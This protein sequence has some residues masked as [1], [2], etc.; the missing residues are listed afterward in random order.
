MAVKRRYLPLAIE[1][2]WAILWKKPRKRLRDKPLFSAFIGVTLSVIPLVLVIQVSDAM[3]SGILNRHLETLSGH[4]QVQF[5]QLEEQSHLQ[6]YIEEL[7]SIKGVKNLHIEHSG[8]GL[9]LNKG[10]RNALQVRGLPPDIFSTD[11][12]F[13]E[14][15]KLISGSFS[16]GPHEIVLADDLARQLQ[17]EVGD[18]ISLLTAAKFGKS[19]QLR[20]KLRSYTLT[21]IISTG[22]QE[23]DRLWAF[24][25]LEEA[26]SFFHSS[27]SQMT[28]YIKVD[29]P[30]D[31]P[32]LEQ[33]R[34][35]VSQFFPIGQ[36]S[37]HSWPK[38]LEGLK[39]TFDFSKSVLLYIMYLIVAVGAINISSA[40]ITLTLENSQDTAIMKVM[41][42]APRLIFQIY[43]CVALLISVIAIFLGFS[44]G[45]VFSLYINQLINFLNLLAS[46]LASVFAGHSTQIDILNKSFY[47]ENIPVVIQVMPLVYAAIIVCLL[48][49]ASAIIPA[50]RAA[51]LLPLEIL[52]QGRN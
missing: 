8:V 6:S 34:S 20:P 17:V 32:Q 21:G 45:L 4:L 11:K 27:N 23:L 7:R 51:K 29:K 28:L 47:L 12:S 1:L 13:P 26:R 36:A 18:S 10:R 42:A 50:L 48:I 35:E 46:F 22:Y 37:V 33:I 39:Q 14:Y 44:I 38:L 43:L 31:F 49:L 25:S 52:R 9:A 41:G 24:V 2:A 5:Y 40:M 3:I 16:L 15:L 30:Y 19:E